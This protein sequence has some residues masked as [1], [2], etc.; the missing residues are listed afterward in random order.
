MAFKIHPTLL[1]IPNL[2]GYFRILAA[3]GAL[4]FCFSSVDLCVLFYAISQGFDAVDG[5]AARHFNQSSKFGAV[6][7]ML[8]DRMTTTC[9]LVVLSLLYRD[10]WGFFAFLIVLDITSH[11]IQMY[12][13][14]LQGAT[15]H[16]GSQ[17]ALLN[18]YYTFPFALLIFCVFNE[19]FLVCLYIKATVF[20]G[21]MIMPVFGVPLVDC[22]QYFAF[23]FFVFKQL[24]NVVQLWD[25]VA[26]LL[27]YDEKPKSS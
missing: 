27:E 16:K 3:I 25:S 7:D 15:T 12:T 2:I 4:S 26:G 6:L 10:I 21:W 9:L 22:C 11:W 24:M 14:L 20:V 19:M 13:K 18:F 8:T 5:V 17:N 1:Y 23:P